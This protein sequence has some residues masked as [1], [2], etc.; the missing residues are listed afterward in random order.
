MS[1]KLSALSLFA[2]SALFM[3][4]AIAQP[5]TAPICAESVRGDLNSALISVR[6]SEQ[7]SALVAVKADTTGNATECKV[8]K[9]GGSELTDRASCEWVKVHW[10][11][12]GRCQ[13]H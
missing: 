13:A 3:D 12:L 5:S 10:P 1:F 2:I 7:G 9:S 6:V 8:L 4:G 11:S